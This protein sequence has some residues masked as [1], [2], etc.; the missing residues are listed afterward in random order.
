MRAAFRLALCL[1]YC[2]SCTL[3]FLPSQSSLR[4][5]VRTSPL[6]PTAG[7]VSTNTLSS[8]SS[9]TALCAKYKKVFVA[10]GSRGVG[11]C[12]IDKLL[13]SDDG[14]GSGDRQV[15]AL[16]RDPADAQALNQLPGVTA[17]VGDARV[18][19]DVENTMDGCDAAIT[20]LGGSSS[21]G[22]T[23][24]QVRIDY[25]GNNHVIESAGILGVTRVILVTSIG[26]G[27]SKEAA[28]PAVFE[29]LKE[30]LAAK[31]KAENILIKYYTNM[32]W[33]IIRPGG[34]KSEPMTGQAILTS[35]VT[36]IGSIHREDVAD[37]VVQALESPATERQVLS[38]ID[39]S[40]TS[41]V[42]MEGKTV[43]AFAL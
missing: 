28:P 22:S 43:A 25:E 11:R 26:C 36:A 35:D 20:T 30:V 38:A 6:R 2:L 13:S 39:P 42:S 40:I 34:L 5:F 7:V 16:V 10:G 33:T 23:A 4:T 8:S 27:T 31:E 21:D 19:K 18:I 24:P 1:N 29:V 12:I 37:L 32:N 41:A 9:S 15:V 3:A 14:D 17:I